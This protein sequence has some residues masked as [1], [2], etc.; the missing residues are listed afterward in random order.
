MKT[1][2]DLKLGDEVYHLVPGPR[3]LMRIAKE[4]GDPVQMAVG[5]SLGSELGK[6]PPL[7]TVV[8]VLGI[9]LAESDYDFGKE[10]LWRLIH[11][12]GVTE[13]FE[14]FAAFIGALV[15]NG[16][17]PEPEAEDAPA[18]NRRARRAKNSR[19]RRGKAKT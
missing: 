8:A 3:A 12:T 18:E 14:P 17:V 10:D 11:E 4:V 19:A 15:N 2:V 13:V 16:V 6:T 1:R 7:A 5:L 9:A